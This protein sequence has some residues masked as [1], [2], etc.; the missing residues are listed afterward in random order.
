MDSNFFNQPKQDEIMKGI[1]AGNFSNANEVLKSESEIEFEDLVA[2]GEVEVVSMEDI[3]ESYQNRFWKG[4]DI[5]AIETAMEALIKK[6]EEEFLEQEEWE[7][8]E[9]AMEDIKSLERKAV[10][11]QVNGGHSYREVYVQASKE[12]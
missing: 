5:A 4:E 6:G 11:V 2:K 7:Q 3:K 12:D 9:K 8:L 1:I 10:A